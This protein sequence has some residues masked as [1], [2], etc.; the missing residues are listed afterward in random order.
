MLNLTGTWKC[1]GDGMT[2]AIMQIGN[3]IYLNGVGNGSINAGTGVVNLDDNGVVLEWA[4]LPGSKGVG[5][6]GVC[7]LDASQSGVISKK[8]GSTSFGIGNFVKVQ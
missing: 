6:H 4:D 8:A 5:N 7:Y 1:S 3:V 2:Y